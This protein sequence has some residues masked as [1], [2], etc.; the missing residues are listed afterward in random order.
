M[1]RN[2]IFE[3][4]FKKTI[5]FLGLGQM[6][7]ALLINF[8]NCLIDNKSNIKNQISDLFFIYD[9]D[10]NKKDIFAN[11]GFNNFVNPEKVLIIT[12]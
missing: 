2:E 5:G 12:N 4:I 8:Y 3:I 1:K 6:G 10:L 7:N 11:L 9:N